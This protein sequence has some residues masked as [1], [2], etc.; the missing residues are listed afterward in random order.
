M[1]IIVVILLSFIFIFNPV[2]EWRK[3]L[4]Y[5]KS[6][7]VYAWDSGESLLL[8][9]SKLL[10]SRGQLSLV[11]ATHQYKFYT[12]LVQENIKQ[13]RK[14]GHFSKE[15]FVKIRSALVSEIL[16]DKQKYKLDLEAKLQMILF[17]L[18]TWSFICSSA[19]LIDIRLGLFK[20]LGILTIQLMGALFYRC[21]T[22]WQER[23]IFLGLP[24]FIQTISVL[25]TI[26]GRV[27][28][29]SA[30]I[31]SGFLELNEIKKTTFLNSIQQKLESCIN[32][33]KQSGA[34]VSDQL[35]IIL[36]EL[37]YERQVLFREF[38]KRLAL[39]KL[40]SL[41]VFFLSSYFYYIYNLFM[42]VLN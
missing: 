9:L 1:L 22:C 18:V 39:I 34:P 2:D 21:A 8:E 6:K 15:Q 14:T 17:F 3:L 16:F 42:H 7:R 26:L 37:F 40:L 13:G 36:E 33:L 19:L 24:Q 38:E 11:N 20:Y 4:N 23:G 31:E 10:T 30:L 27:N 29:K 12:N 28:I 32:R 5:L 41:F 35:D 25:N